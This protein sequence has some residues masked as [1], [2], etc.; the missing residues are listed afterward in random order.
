MAELFILAGI[1][2]K[3]QPDLHIFTITT[4]NTESYSDE[5]INPYITLFSGSI[6]NNFFLLDDN[7]RTLYATL[8]INSLDRS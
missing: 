7:A 5:V 4:M 1:N 3:L 8:V 2:L 6:S